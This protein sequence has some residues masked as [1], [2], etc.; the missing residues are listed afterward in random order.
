MAAL[1]GHGRAEMRRETGDGRRGNSLPCI[2]AGLLVAC[3][4]T[5]TLPP[6]RI[7]PPRATPVPVEPAP[8]PTVTRIAREGMID[9]GAGK[10]WYHIAGS[11]ADTVVVP[12][13]SWLDAVAIAARWSAH[14]RVLRSPASGT[15]ASDGRL[16]RGNIRWR[17]G[18]PR[19]VARRDRRATNIGH[20]LRLLRRR[21]RC[22]GGVAS[23]GG[24]AARAAQPH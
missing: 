8:T 16:R 21:C 17:R 22:L 14:R 11:G 12:L 10:L 24:D 15:L 6:A 1:R 7:P 4:P 5:T 19:G 3:A 18:G 20:R 13:A 23:A 2:L 9:G